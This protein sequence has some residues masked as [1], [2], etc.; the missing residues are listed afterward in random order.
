MSVRPHGHMHAGASALHRFGQTHL[1][2]D[3]EHL[4]R[5]APRVERDRSEPNS[6]E[7]VEVV[8]LGCVVRRAVDNDGVKRRACARKP[9]ITQSASAMALPREHSLAP[10]AKTALPFVHPYA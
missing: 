2:G 4:V 1:R 8:A 6:R 10:V 9:A 5:D 7:D 3:V